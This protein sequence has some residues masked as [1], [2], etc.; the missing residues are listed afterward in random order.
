M[1]RRIIT[2]T[3]SMSGGKHKTS[4]W[5]PSVRLSICPEAHDAARQFRPTKKNIF[6]S[7][8]MLNIGAEDCRLHGTNL[9]TEPTS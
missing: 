3:V 1:A 5:R 7:R 8:D 4:V 9:V 6:S 2:L